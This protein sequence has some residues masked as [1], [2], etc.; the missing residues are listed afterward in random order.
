MHG[1][2]LDQLGRRDPEHYGSLTLDQLEQEIERQALAV[3]LRTQFFRTNHEGEFVERLHRLRESV[4]AVV[5]N[6]GAWTHYSWAIRDALELSGVPAV[7]VHLSA[8]EER[9]QWRQLS[10]LEGV[11]IGKVSGKGPAGYADALALLAEAIA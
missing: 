3:G 6:P 11:V 8:V 4:D 5:L 1:V 2:N 9:E 7:E 10:V